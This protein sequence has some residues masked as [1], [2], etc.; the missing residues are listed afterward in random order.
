MRIEPKPEARHTLA[1][2]CAHQR[3][4]R[5]VAKT[6][7]DMFLTRA[8]SRPYPQEMA[9]NYTQSRTSWQPAPI[10]RAVNAI[11]HWQ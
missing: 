4:F 5:R 11:H 2:A 3:L 9:T 6:L 8:E 1:G 7:Q 10:Q